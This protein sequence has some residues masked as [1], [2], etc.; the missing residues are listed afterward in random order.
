MTT[1]LKHLER[2]YPEIYK[3][4]DFRWLSENPN[5]RI[6]DVLD[7]PDENWNWDELSENPGIQLQDI[8]NHLD[9]PWSWNGYLKIQ[10]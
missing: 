2:D 7:H 6:K 1:W 3:R 9:L 4:L 5:I 8:I 10:I